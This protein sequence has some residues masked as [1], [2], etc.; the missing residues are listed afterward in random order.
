MMCQVS[1]KVT[2]YFLRNQCL[3]IFGCQISCHRLPQ[4]MT[5][6]CRIDRKADNFLSERKYKTFP[7]NQPGL[8]FSQ[9]TSSTPSETYDVVHPSGAVAIIGHIDDLARFIY[10]TC[11]IDLR[12]IRHQA[13]MSHVL[14]VEELQYGLFLLAHQQSWTIPQILAS[15]AKLST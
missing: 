1:Q 5:K 4:K 15:P 12:S 10:E 11:F 7:I 9:L 8:M 6:I 14:H 2:F 3:S 13:P